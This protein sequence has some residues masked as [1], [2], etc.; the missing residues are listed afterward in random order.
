ML[1][2][3]RRRGV[4]MIGFKRKSRVYD[5]AVSIKKWVRHD[6]TSLM[7]KTVVLSI[8]L[9]QRWLSILLRDRSKRV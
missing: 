9:L 3:I 8:P 5:V 6:A 1:G 2:C 4:S 7:I